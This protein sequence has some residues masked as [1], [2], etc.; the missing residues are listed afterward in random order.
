MSRER[1]VSLVEELCKELE[2]ADTAAVLQRCAMEVAG[3]EVLL[4]HMSSDENAMYM[5]FNFGI[6]SGGRTLHAFHMMLQSNMTLYAQDQAQLGVHPE[7]GSP[8]LIVRV[9]MTDEIDGPWLADT[10]NHYCEHG[11][12]WRQNLHDAHDEENMVMPH[13][14]FI[15]MRA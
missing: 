9:P 13:T 7:T 2:I 10:F 4:T 5:N 1:Y 6:V 12:Y 8:L 3:Y 14:H 11:R 15:W